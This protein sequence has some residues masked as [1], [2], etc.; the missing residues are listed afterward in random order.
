MTINNNIILQ[1]I[2]LADQA[3]VSTVQYDHSPTA[4]NIK[5]ATKP[6]QGCQMVYKEYGKFLANNFKNGNVIGNMKIGQE[7]V[8]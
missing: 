8:F 3:A 4:A 1:Y 6:G 7:N 2:I 5:T